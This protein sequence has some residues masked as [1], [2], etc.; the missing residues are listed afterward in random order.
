[1]IFNNNKKKL[2]EY[3]EKLKEIQA[4]KKK[5]ESMADAKKSR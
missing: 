5:V 4:E 3:E 1:M 2:E